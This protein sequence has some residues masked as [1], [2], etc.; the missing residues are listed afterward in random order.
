M[1]PPPQPRNNNRAEV[2]AVARIVLCLISVS[3]DW[4]EK[5]QG[6]YFMARGVA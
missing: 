4:K 2:R 3:F 1:T 5:V 6:G